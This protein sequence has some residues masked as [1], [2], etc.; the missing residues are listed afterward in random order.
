MTVL[1]VLPQRW[2][3]HLPHHAPG[4]GLAAPTSLAPVQAAT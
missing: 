2:V 1:R 4:P 3:L